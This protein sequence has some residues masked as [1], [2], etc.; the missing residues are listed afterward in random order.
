M[1][2][3]FFANMILHKC[4]CPYQLEYKLPNNSLQKYF[5]IFADL[6]VVRVQLE[7][8]LTLSNANCNQTAS[9]R[10][11]T[12]KYLCKEILFLIYV[13]IY[14]LADKGKSCGTAMQ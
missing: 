11:K 8:N 2:L 1:T 6:S 13:G 14:F 12:E 9:R 4:I 7:L 5:P 10:A 3:R